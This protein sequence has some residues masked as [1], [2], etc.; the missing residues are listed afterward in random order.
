MPALNT[1]KLTG[2]HCQDGAVKDRSCSRLA[3]TA[4]GCA[5]FVTNNHNASSIKSEK[6][7]PDSTVPLSARLTSFFLAVCCSSWS[8]PRLARF[9]ATN[10]NAESREEL[11]KDEDQVGAQGRLVLE[12]MLCFAYRHPDSRTT[13]KRWTCVRMDLLVF[14]KLAQGHSKRVA[15][16]DFRSICTNLLVGSV[17]IFSWTSF[18]KNKKRTMYDG[19]C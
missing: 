16:V 3:T 2:Y 9:P 11:V 10:I 13:S 7:P 19:A 12:D 6:Q 5:L 4:V 15:G 17:T 14:T 8:C 18:T 1:S